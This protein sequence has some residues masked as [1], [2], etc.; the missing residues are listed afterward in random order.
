MRIHFR[1]TPPS[2]PVQAQPRI[3]AVVVSDGVIT[4]LAR[5]QSVLNRM[6]FLR[7]NTVTITRGCKCGR[8]TTQR[9]ADSAEIARVR[10]AMLGAPAESIAYLKSMLH[11]DQLV[12]YINENGAV[13]KKTL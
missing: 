6:P 1:R 7:L 5:N 9:V 2:S 12:F 4:S 11:A 3:K 13:V 8:G 10:R